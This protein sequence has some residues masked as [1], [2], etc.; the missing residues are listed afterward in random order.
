MEGCYIGA[1][2]CPSSVS[3]LFVWGHITN[4]REAQSS[5]ISADT[6]SALYLAEISLLQLI[7]L[8]ARD[9]ITRVL[10][11]SPCQPC[12]LLT[13]SPA[14]TSLSPGWHHLPDITVLR[15]TPLPRHPCAQADH[16]SA[17]GSFIL[18]RQFS[19]INW[20]NQGHKSQ[21]RADSRIINRALFSSWWL[22]QSSSF[23]PMSSNAS[24]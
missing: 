8:W 3:V 1:D 18:Q 15:L 7:K 10:S 23:T 4:Y 2:Y 24:P 6:Q 21:S 20:T 13:L 9:R 16:S 17:V 11:D 14:I 22:L 12:W 5:L 19:W